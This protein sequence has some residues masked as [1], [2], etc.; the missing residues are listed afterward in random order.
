MLYEG[1]TDTVPGC[2]WELDG[3][4]RREM[5][6]EEE[7]D[8]CYNPRLVTVDALIAAEQ[9]VGASHVLGPL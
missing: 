7:L 5:L 3:R 2:F 6:F 4:H 9:Y 1:D 8:F